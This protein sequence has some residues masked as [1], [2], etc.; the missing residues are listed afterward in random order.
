MADQPSNFSCEP[1]RECLAADVAKVQPDTELKNTLVLRRRIRV[2]VLD[3][4]SGEPVLGQPVEEV[5]LNGTKLATFLAL[6]KEWDIA[7]H[8]PISGSGAQRKFG[9]N[10]VTLTKATQI[11]L[12]ALGY[13]C[14]IPSN[15]YGPQGMTAFLKFRVVAQAVRFKPED[16]AKIGLFDAAVLKPNW[17]PAPGKKVLRGAKDA[18]DND[19]EFRAPN[20]SEANELIRIYNTKCY[21]AAQFHLA[22]LD[23]YPRDDAKLK[24]GVLDAPDSGVWTDAWKEAFKDWQHLTFSRAKD[25]CYDWVKRQEEGAALLEQKR[26][27]VTDEHGDIFIPIPVTLLTQSIKVGVSFRDFTVV[28]EATLKEHEAT[29][30]KLHRVVTRRVNDD[31]SWGPM[32][33]KPGTTSFA[34][35]WVTQ[36]QENQWLKPW[37]WRCGIER[38]KSNAERQQFKEFFTAWEF[39][40][41]AFTQAE[42]DDPKT[43]ADW[44]ALHKRTKAFNMFYQAADE[45]PEFVLFALVWCQPVWDEFKDPELRGLGAAAS[46]DAYVWPNQGGLG[47]AREPDDPGVRDTPAHMHIVTQY[48]D[49]GGSDKFGGKGYGLFEHDK[50][51]DG[52]QAATVWRGGDGHHGIDVHADIGDLLFAVHAGNA[53]HNPS[54]GALGRTVSVSWMAADGTSYNIAGGHLSAA[55]GAFKRYVR[56]GEIVGRAGRTGNLSPTSNQAGH[57]HL[58]VGY[59]AATSTFNLAYQSPDEANRCCIPTNYR[60]PLLLPCRCATVSDHDALSGCN[61]ADKDIAS[62]C[63]AVNDLACPHLPREKVTL[64]DLTAAGINA[65]KR[66]VQAQLRK[67][68]H[69]TGKLDGDWGSFE[70]VLKVTKAGGDGIYAATNSSSAKR[71]TAPKDM[72]LNV[73]GT[74][75]GWYEVEIQVALRTATSGDRGWIAAASVADPSVGG[76]R[77]GICAFKTATNL[78]PASP[79]PKDKFE[80]DQPFLDRLNQDAPVIPLS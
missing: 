66:Q 30:S 77:K 13:E 44:R 65:A 9:L 56:A 7:K 28:P 21:R 29:G 40:I 68:G 18:A 75:S 24:D 35:E 6:D 54:N 11:V 61:F 34:I 3:C 63:W 15:T 49:M 4:R 76:T 62:A 8:F 27:F 17:R 64:A 67:L 38:S 60:T 69:Y 19:V 16:L 41:P 59:S 20:D 45:T 79:S 78:L 50:D 10:N 22:S 31:G 73:L 48:Y 70:N 74:A 12:N 51:A 25:N 55:E 23:F 52:S 71:A 72:K 80:A 58:N 47:T 14:G 33:P 26:G 53:K 5:R 32:Q 39:E 37:G 2:R 43:G 1:A 42:L 57:V 36:T 46:N